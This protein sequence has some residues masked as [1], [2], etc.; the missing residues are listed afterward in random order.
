MGKRRLDY[1]K[2][3]EKRS[4]L[5]SEDEFRPRF[6]NGSEYAC[7]FLEQNFD[8]VSKK[9]KYGPRYF[10]KQ[11]TNDYCPKRYN[12]PYGF[13]NREDI[14]EFLSTTITG[15]GDK[16]EKELKEKYLKEINKKYKVWKKEN[17][18]TVFMI[19]CYAKRQKYMSTEKLMH[20]IED[21]GYTMPPIYGRQFFMCLVEDGIIEL[22]T[23]QPTKGNNNG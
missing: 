20:Y 1:N 5:S 6:S 18:K 16:K 3:Q 13:K 10:L 15:T 19:Q 2:V 11:K 21:R 4:C 14:I 12:L 22:Y 23:K 7:K 8:I 17:H 9:T